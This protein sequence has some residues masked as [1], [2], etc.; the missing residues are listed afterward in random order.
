MSHNAAP[1]LQGADAPHIASD[2]PLIIEEP[3][4]D[5]PDYSLVCPVHQWASL[6]IPELNLVPDCPY[7]LV[8]SQSALGHERYRQI[9]ARLAA[10]S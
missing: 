2:D 10:R 5:G 8:E 7:C 4:R 9:H 6:P 1:F 3:T